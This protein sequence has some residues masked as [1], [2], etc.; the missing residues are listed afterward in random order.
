M[1][2]R[3]LKNEKGQ[4]IVEFALVVPILLTLLCGIIDFGWIDSNQYKVENAAYA[5]ARYA[6][7]YVSDYNSSN[8]NELID[9]IDNRVK[10]NLWNNGEGANVTVN[11]TSDKIEVTVVYPV[12]NLTYV[13]QTFFGKYYK[14]KSASVTSI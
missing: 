9:K 1:L 13:A 5:G 4:S 12:K 6:S 14:A 10:E 11:I 2:R 3:I 7:L 8:M